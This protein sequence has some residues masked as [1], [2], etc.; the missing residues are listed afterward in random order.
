MYYNNDS[1]VN[2]EINIFVTWRGWKKSK[3]T[4]TATTR[5]CAG[6]EALKKTTQTKKTPRNYYIGLILGLHSRVIPIHTH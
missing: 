4:S 5:N 2:C 3:K 6:N 1:Y